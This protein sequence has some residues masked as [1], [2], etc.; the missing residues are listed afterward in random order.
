MWKIDSRDVS[1]G[2]ASAVSTYD[3]ASMDDKLHEQ[4]GEF[5]SMQGPEPTEGAD[6]KEQRK[7]KR[8]RERER[9]KQ[10]AAVSFWRVTRFY[11][12][13]TH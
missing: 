2:V 5:A 1:P 9:E 4:R 3:R 6:R 10:H 12:Y 13:P 8:K 11:I 7:R